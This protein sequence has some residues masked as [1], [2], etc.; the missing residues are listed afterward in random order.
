MNHRELYERLTRFADRV[1]ALA[2]PML[3]RPVTARRADQ[4]MRASAAAAANYRASNYG[5]SHAEFRSK[6]TTALEEIDEARHWLVS[7]HRNGHA[8]GA[9]AESLLVEVIEL[10]RILGAS[11]RTA[12]RNSRR[13]ADRTESRPPRTP[14]VRTPPEKRRAAENETKE[15]VEEQDAEDSGIVK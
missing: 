6:L 3:G 13:H 11:R 5:R 15:E 7:L 14:P 4:L 2:E 10:T 1:E 8:T 12:N 9:G